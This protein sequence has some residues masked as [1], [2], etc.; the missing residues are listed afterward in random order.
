MKGLP[1]LRE[2]IKYHWCDVLLDA[3]YSREYSTLPVNDLWQDY[4][5]KITFEYGLGVG[6][7]ISA[8][9][10]IFVFFRFIQGWWLLLPLAFCIL[11][12][13]VI[14]SIFSCIYLYIRMR[15]Y[16]RP[17]EEAEEAAKAKA[18]ESSAHNKSTE[19]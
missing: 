7:C 13:F 15:M 9:I 19:R 2:V 11:L 5:K 1:L 6:I 8:L 16:Y 4:A 14:S 3:L 17:I 10:F 12:C 18:Q